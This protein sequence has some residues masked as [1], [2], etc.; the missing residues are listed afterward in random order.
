MGKIK[1]ISATYFLGVTR[2]KYI[3][4]TQ[5]LPHI[6]LLESS[7]MSKNI[8]NLDKYEKRIL[9]SLALNG[10]M[11]QIQLSDSN[12]KPVVELERWGVG[13]YLYG[14]PK[15]MGLIPYGYVSVTPRDKRENTYSLTTKGILASIANTP[16]KSNILFRKY[17][18][19]VTQY[20]SI[21]KSHVFVKKFVDEFVKLFLIWHYLHGI[22]LTKQKLPENYYMNFFESI[23]K[24]S[25]IKINPLQEKEKKEF[26]K[27]MNNCITFTTILDLLSSGEYFKKKTLFSIV[28]WKKTKKAKRDTSND[29]LFGQALWEWP[30]FIVKN[31]I[32]LNWE[33][34][35]HALY[36][37]YSPEITQK[38]KK[39]LVQI[40]AKI[41]WK[42]ELDSST[43]KLS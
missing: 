4:N 17:V 25:T 24:T 5:K 8:F 42:S 39:N 41:R 28:D 26:N 19:F 35:E 11:N 14:T 16:L 32:T 22:N 10:P 7:K 36:K 3:Q 13:G 33:Q 2:N 34:E 43:R 30:N 12:T 37:Y 23:R 38:V 20:S 15:H 6:L 9:K 31:T 29:H 18:K 1:V 27:V 21:K 40:E